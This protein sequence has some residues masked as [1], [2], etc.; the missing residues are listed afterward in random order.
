MVHYNCSFCGK[1]VSKNCSKTKQRLEKKLDCYCDRSC[2]NSAR[3]PSEEHR[4]HT[5]ESLRKFNNNFTGHSKPRLSRAKYTPEE[6]IKRDEEKKKL[7]VENQIIH[8]FINC[9]YKFAVEAYH[10]RKADGRIQKYTY[11]NREKSEVYNLENW[12]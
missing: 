2:A 8:N 9:G 12:R 6:R 10:E 11:K 3:V 7:A 1:H 4:Q 5:A